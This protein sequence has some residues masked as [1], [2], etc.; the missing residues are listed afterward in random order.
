MNIF[1]NKPHISTVNIMLCAFLCLALF[2]VTAA[3]TARADD[4]NT[5]FQDVNRSLA[6]SISGINDFIRMLNGGND[7]DQ[8]D[9]GADYGD[10]STCLIYGDNDGE[11]L[12]FN[13]DFRRRTT[14]S[15]RNCVMTVGD[16]RDPETRRKFEEMY[17]KDKYKDE[18]KELE[19]AIA[20]LRSGDQINDEFDDNDDDDETSDECDENDQDEN[21]GDENCDKK[22]DETAEGDDCEKATNLDDKIECYRTGKLPDKSDKDDYK[23]DDKDDD[24]DETAECNESSSGGSCLE[25][26]PS[27]DPYPKYNPADNPQ[28]SFDNPDFARGGSSDAPSDAKT[29]GQAP[30]IG[31]ADIKDILKH[32]EGS[33]ETCCAEEVSLA[34]ILKWEGCPHPPKDLGDGVGVT[35]CGLTQRYSG[36]IV[37]NLT[38]RAL[39]DHYKNNYFD[40][41]KC[42]STEM[43]GHLLQCWQS[44]I[45]MGPDD[46]TRWQQRTPPCGYNN[47][48]CMSQE[49][50]A[51]I[52][53]ISGKNGGKWKKGWERRCREASD[54]A[55]Q[56]DNLGK[57]GKMK[58]CG[59]EWT[60]AT[61]GKIGLPRGG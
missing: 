26:D 27:D 15:N 28:A 48:P 43:P 41:A 7:V 4:E 9:D 34:Q 40:K 22:D 12:S 23:D 54:I 32:C 29:Y 56:L 59:S 35:T 42:F 36:N 25:T 6:D 49:Y 45:H 5:D 13:T 60:N 19:D 46:P 51:K 3:N 20:E 11:D 18:I 52:E 1:G 17:N 33:Q 58:V 31:V 44:A 38:E 21:D 47:S 55:I 24:K 37:F 50:C 53:R 61:T 39:R 2:V 16:I 8:T 57:Q 30:N 10:N 14:T